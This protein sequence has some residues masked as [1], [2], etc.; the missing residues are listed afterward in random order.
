MPSFPEIECWLAVSVETAAGKKYEHLL[1]EE[2]AGAPTEVFTRLR[3]VVSAAHEDAR[4]RIRRLA[5]VSLDPLEAGNSKDPA[6][7]YPEKLHIQ[8]LK[9]YFGEVMAGVVAENLCPFGLADW[10]V[11][12]YL[13]RFHNVAFQQLAMLNETGAPA[14]KIPGRTG[15]DCLA[16]RRNGGGEIVGGLFC[17]AKCTGDHNSGMISDAHEKSSLPNLLPVDLLQLVEILDNSSDSAAKGWAEALRQLHLRGIDAGSSFERI[18]QVTYICGRKP[19]KGGGKCWI[20]VDKPHHKYTAGRKLHVAEIHLN[21]VVE[22]IKKAYGV[23]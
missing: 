5:G 19:V 1:G 15:D 11:P 10:K 18:D 6:A 14:G 23:I 16:F 9:G 13:F 20:P 12:A 3:E 8:T 2:K 22:A 17:E 4:D 21:D 7:G